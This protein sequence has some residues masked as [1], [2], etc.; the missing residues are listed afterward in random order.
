MIK[1]E[2]LWSKKNYCLHIKS[3]GNKNNELLAK[4]IQNPEG[5]NFKNN[6]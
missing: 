4:K 3:L 1:R 6:F 5:N 2:P